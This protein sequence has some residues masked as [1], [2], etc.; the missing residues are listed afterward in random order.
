MGLSIDHSSS[1]KSYLLC[2]VINTPRP[3]AWWREIFLV[4]ATTNM[5]T[6][7]TLSC[8]RPR[9]TLKSSFQ[10]KL[11]NS[12]YTEIKLYL[13]PVYFKV[14]KSMQ[15]KLQHNTNMSPIY[16]KATHLKVSTLLW[17]VSAKLAEE[18]PCKP[19]KKLTFLKFDF[20]LS[21]TTASTTYPI[22]N[23]TLKL[24]VAKWD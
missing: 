21:I 2:P 13:D 9:L 12:I 4:N 3:N 19:Q 10:R 1:V 15:H 7:E 5:F 14:L 20:K 23:G 24:E 18:N 17:K 6:K 8:F 16:C 11:W 22:R